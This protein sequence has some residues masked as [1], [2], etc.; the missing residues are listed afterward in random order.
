MG[1]PLSIISWF[2][3]WIEAGED[4]LPDKEPSYRWLYTV[5]HREVVR[6]YSVMT[7]FNSVP[8]LRHLFPSSPVLLELKPDRSI[9]SSLQFGQ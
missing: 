1:A 2:T 7:I 9:T 3:R 4:R 8:Q 5:T 6:P